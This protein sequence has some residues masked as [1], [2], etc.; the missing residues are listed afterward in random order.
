MKVEWEVQREIRKQCPQ[1][2]SHV[3][4]LGMGSGNEIRN[5]GG[6][7]CIFKALR[8]MIIEKL[9]WAK[10]RSRYSNCYRKWR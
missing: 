2:E 10:L 1:T 4:E 8:L 3:G 7:T 5:T 9:A 6:R